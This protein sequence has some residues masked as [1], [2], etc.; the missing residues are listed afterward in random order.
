MLRVPDELI[1]PRHGWEKQSPEGI[2]E[3][4]EAWLH[5]HQSSIYPG[6]DATSPVLFAIS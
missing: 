2:H 3:G 6:H 5:E 1:P 4:A